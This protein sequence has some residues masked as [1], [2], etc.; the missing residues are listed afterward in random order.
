M[1]APLGI[2]VSHYQDTTPS[3]TGLSFLIA[4]AS[5]GT[6]PDDRYRAHIAHARAFGLVTGAYHFGHPAVAVAAQVD[7]FLAAAGDV[8]LYALDI[9][10]NNMTLA[11]AR[12][13]IAGV[14]ARGLLCGLYAS[15]SAYPDIGQDWR[16]VAHWGVAQPS[17]PW[18]IHQY[19]GSPLDLDRY[20]GTI[21][22]L[23]ALAGE[24]MIPVAMNGPFKVTLKVGTQLYDQSFKPLVKVSK[25]QVA[26]GFFTTGLTGGHNYVAIELVTGGK[27]QLVFAIVSSVAVSAPPAVDTVT[28]RR[29]EY[30]RV[31]DATTLSAHFPPRP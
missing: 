14:Q 6:L 2:D 5:E 31:V 27:R 29:A 13:F 8:G 16:W 10:S 17:I 23:R 30:D 20:N 1:T 3:L 15:E 4:K 24:A 18:D 9:E 11:R 28:I 25:A 12:A 21:E 19:R 26:D 7:A 22:Q